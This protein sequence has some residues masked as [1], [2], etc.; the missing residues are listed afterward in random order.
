MHRLYSFVQLLQA[1]I[2][3]IVPRFVFVGGL[4]FIGFAF[5]FLLFF[6]YSRQKQNRFA[7]EKLLLKADF[8][9]QLLHSRIEVQEATMSMLSKE[10][11]DNIGQLISSSK[12]LVRVGQRNGADAAEALQKADDTLAAAISELRSL[13]KSFDKDW[14]SQFDFIENLYTEINR[15]LSSKE[16][17][18]HFE[19]QQLGLN[20][21]NDHQII[22]FRITQEAI[23]NAIKHAEATDIYIRICMKNGATV[24]EIEDNGKGMELSDLNHTGLGMI[25]IKNRS[26]LIGGEAHWISAPGRGTLLKIVLPDQIPVS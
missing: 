7:A 10:L 13:A 8:D 6:I 12:F 1:E 26:K 23:Q 4:L 18:M 2:K 22:L 14:L 24:V 20:L 11:H 21:A 25:N 19:C 17:Y 5:V 16:I 9:K 3:D 15:I